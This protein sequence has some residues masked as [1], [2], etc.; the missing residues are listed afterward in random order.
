MLGKE[1]V[2][3]AIV[4]ALPLLFILPLDLQYKVLFLVVA[5]FS[6]L[7]PDIDEENSIIYKL[8]HKLDKPLLA[9]LKPV[10][11]V[12]QVAAYIIRYLVLYPLWLLI[13]SLKGHRLITHSLLF[14]LF[15]TISVYLLIYVL[16]GW[17]LA[18]VI[19]MG[20]LIGL[21]SHLIGDSLTISG[22]PLLL[23]A[24]IK[25]RGP[26]ITGKTS[27]IILLYA[28]VFSIVSLYFILNYSAILGICL[29]FVLWYSYLRW[30][31]EIKRI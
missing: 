28:L 26:Y 21:I 15:I 9:I 22:V 12:F 23:P 19:G 3:F 29:Y 13:P 2:I 31:I 7:I 30:K 10:G 20:L 24:K 6:A 4:I 11:L 1:H 8:S 27:W 18:I 25:F 14:T 17:K 5:S 16:F